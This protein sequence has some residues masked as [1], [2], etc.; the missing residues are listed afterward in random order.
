MTIFLIYLNLLSNTNFHVF[1]T[2][3]SVYKRNSPVFVEI[4]IPL[5]CF[6]EAV[7]STLVSDMRRLVTNANHAEIKFSVDGQLIAA[8]KWFTNFNKLFFIFVSVY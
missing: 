1:E 7:R 5:T 3:V 8:H 6:L 2:F 4:K